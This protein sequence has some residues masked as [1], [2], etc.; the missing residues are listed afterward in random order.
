MT[1]LV[2]GEN[3]T[4]AADEQVLVTSDTGTWTI[5]LPASP[6]TGDKV[7]VWDCGDNAGSNVITVARNGNT[8]NGAAE[9]FLIN[10]DG[11]RWD[12][13]YGGTTWEYSYVIQTTQ[14]QPSVAE[15]S[16]DWYPGQM[17][18]QTGGPAIPYVDDHA[19]GVTGSGLTTCYPPYRAFDASNNSKL[20][21][22]GKM[23]A[24]WDG[25]TNTVYFHITWF[26]DNTN[27][28]DCLWWFGM[29]DL[30]V[31]L[32]QSGLLIMPTAAN[33]TQY[34]LQTTTGQ[35]NLALRDVNPGDE[36]TMTLQRRAADAGDTFT[37]NAHFVHCSL[38]YR[39]TSESIGTAIANTSSMVTRNITGT[40]DTI[41]AS[42][43]GKTL[44]YTNAAAV[45]VTLPDGLPVD[46]QCTVMQYG[47]GTVTVTPATDTVNGAG[48]GVSPAAQYDS[49]YLGK[50]EATGWVAVS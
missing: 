43:N 35:V 24:D 1:A 29:G 30:Y 2:K 49:L 16:M 36:I 33:G 50:V 46:F 10:M 15:T 45:A 27:T 23:P 13:V 34:Q 12:G 5:T 18:T 39:R 26:P 41:L 21:W 3:Y 11:G 31:D 20:F 22:T 28:Q 17:G 38:S 14:P 48:T 25:D 40:T 6:T 42:D 32:E 19:L 9:D 4:A 47:A 44:V 8:I 37:G 7:S